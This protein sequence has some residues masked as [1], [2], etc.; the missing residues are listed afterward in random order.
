MSMMLIENVDGILWLSGNVMPSEEKRLNDELRQ[1][2]KVTSK[3]ARIVDMSAVKYISSSAAKTLLTIA[4]EATARG[5]KLKVRSSIPVVRTL[6]L[7]GAETWCD[8]EPCR[9]PSRKPGQTSVSSPRIV[10]V[11]PSAQKGD[12]NAR[13]VPVDPSVAKRDSNTNLTPAGGSPADIPPTLDDMEIKEAL[14]ERKST[15]GLNAPGTSIIKHSVGQTGAEAALVA[16]AAAKAGLPLVNDDAELDEELSAL[17]K[18]V[19]MKTYTF[20]MPGLKTDITGKVL[21][22]VGGPW[23]LIDTH[24]AKKML[25]IK[26]VSIIDILA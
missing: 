18:L 10:P 22:R 21:A 7:L 20:Q 4:Q 2:I 3:D 14:S 26:Q 15:V 16:G 24:G 8:V 5:G 6:S 19:V 25:N 12:S 11:A 9:E 13:L 23:I 1:Y 17:K